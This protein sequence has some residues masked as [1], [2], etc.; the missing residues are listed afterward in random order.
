MVINAKS[1]KVIS[2][3]E[4]VHNSLHHNQVDMIQAKRSTGSILKPFLYLS[5]LKSGKILPQTLLS[6]V[7]NDFDGYSPKNY[8]LKC[9][10]M[11]PADQVVSR[12]LNIPSVNMLHTYG[13]NQ[14]MSDLKQYGMTSLTKTAKH[15]G[16]SLILG[17]A[18]VSPWDL[19]QMY[20]SLVQQ[21]NGH[22]QRVSFLK[23]DTLKHHKI[24][25]DKPSIWYTFNSMLNVVRPNEEVSWRAFTSSRQVAWKTGTSFGGRD[26][27]AVGC[28]PEY[29]VVVWSGN[30]NGEGRPSL[31]GYSCSAPI[32]FDIINYLNPSEKWFE[33]PE[34]SSSKVKACSQSGM[35][36][37]TYCVNSTV[38]QVP[39]KGK[40]SPLCC[41]CTQVQ[42]DK[43]GTYD[44][45]NTDYPPLDRINK[46][47]F[48]L[49]PVESY[50]YHK[51]NNKHKPLLKNTS[52]NFK[53][54]YPK[55]DQKIFL[56]KL[57][58]NTKSN[59]I[60]TVYTTETSKLFWIIDQEYKGT[61]SGLHELQL[62]P[63]PGKHELTII[64]ENGSR[65]SVTFEVVE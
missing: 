58:K 7:P 63:N 54:E 26:A 61:T 22:N 32:L 39:S 6:D 18:E 23:S 59:F 46:T 38:Q 11:V 15:Y 2:Y 14:F 21:I 5:M 34:Q 44:V 45:T 62:S 50:Y 10:G 65:K 9:D 43:T 40:D 41:Y 8:D 52:F 60:A 30:A 33:Y 64:N 1:G 28:T 37:N 24:N 12:S 20:T 48:T 31:T 17:G 56:P 57:N 36:A 35:K 4:N 42:L 27:W 16:L 51:S 47:V 49:P 3:V 29:V 55:N 53:I 19:G 13:V 25:I